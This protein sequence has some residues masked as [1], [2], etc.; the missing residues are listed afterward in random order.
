M[1]RISRLL[2]PALVVLALLATA[3]QPQVVT[4]TVEVVV[5]KEVPL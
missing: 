5:T 1:F 3:C 2:W 4:Q